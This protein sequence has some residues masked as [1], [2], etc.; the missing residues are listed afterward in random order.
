MNL[1]EEGHEGDRIRDIFTGMGG[2]APLRDVARRCLEAAVW[3][4]VQIESMQLNGAVKRVKDALRTHVNGSGLPF[5]AATDKSA[6]AIWKQREMFAYEDYVSII[7]MGVDALGADHAKLR[8]WQ[9]ECRD[10]HGTAPSIPDL[11]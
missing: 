8:A 3:D 2:S 5:A 7:S 10:R 4:E 6:K 1:S 11:V 9:A